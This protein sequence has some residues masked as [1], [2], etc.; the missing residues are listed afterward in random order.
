MTTSYS[1]QLPDGSVTWAIDWEKG[2]LAGKIG[3]KQSALQSAAVRLLVPRYRHLI[4]S[5]DF[6]SEIWDFWAEEPGFFAASA[7]DL[8]WEAL[9]QDERMLSVKDVSFTR[10]GDS[11]S[12][13]F[14]LKT[15]DGSGEVTL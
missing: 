5:G 1:L 6:G 3:G 15:V 8:I 10:N 13:A 12:L 14:T 7:E 9:R 11:A 4:Y 2:R